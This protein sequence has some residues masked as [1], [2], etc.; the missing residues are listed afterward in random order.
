MAAQTASNTS[1]SSA[2]L[3]VVNVDPE[4]ALTGL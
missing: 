2:H 1:G 4:G 3:M